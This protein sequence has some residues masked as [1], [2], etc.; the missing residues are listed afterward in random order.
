M[1][2]RP[3]TKDLIFCG[4]FNAKLNKYKLIWFHDVRSRKNAI[5]KGFVNCCNEMIT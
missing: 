2:I 5:Y 3:L 4:T 1:I